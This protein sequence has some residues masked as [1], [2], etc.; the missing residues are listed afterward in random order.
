MCMENLRKWQSW[1]ELLL[2]IE[3][4]CSAVAVMCEFDWKIRGLRLLTD[5]AL[6]PYT[7]CYSYPVAI[8]PQALHNFPKAQVAANK[9]ANNVQHHFLAQFFM[10]F[11]MVRSIL[12]GVLALQT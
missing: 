3:L 8:K 11:H 9:N 7:T 6:L 12:F 5:R 2:L 1:Q 10:L 4:Q